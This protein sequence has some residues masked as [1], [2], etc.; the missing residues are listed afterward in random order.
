MT[1]AGNRSA[2]SQDSQLGITARWLVRP[3]VGGFRREFHG[4]QINL[5]AG[6][7]RHG[8]AVLRSKSSTPSLTV[9]SV[10]FEKRAR[11]ERHSAPTPPEAHYVLTG[12]VGSRSKRWMRSALVSGNCPGREGGSLR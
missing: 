6:P 10:A 5:I 3:R 12:D 2:A 11:A 9:G 7:R 4:S 8:A 1:S